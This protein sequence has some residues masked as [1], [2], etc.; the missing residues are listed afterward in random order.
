MSRRRLEALR[1]LAARPGNEAE[2]RV[3]REK[4]KSFEKKHPDTARS[5]GFW[6][7]LTYSGA[8]SGFGFPLRATCYCGTEYDFAKECPNTD[9]HEFIRAEIKTRFKRGDRVYYNYWAYSPN[10]PAT[11]AGYLRGDS[12]SWFWILLKFDH[13]KQVRSVPIYSRLGWHL[14]SEPVLNGE[15]LRGPR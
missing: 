6:V 5:S 15:V 14:S 1:N 13:L 3:A 10:C 7:S 12:R 4:L 8:G 9:R 2:G 11:V